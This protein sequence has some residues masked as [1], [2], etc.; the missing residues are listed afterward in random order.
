MRNHQYKQ[1][2]FLP[3][4]NSNPL[5]YELINLVMNGNED[6]GD[7]RDLEGSNEPDPKRARIDPEISTETAQ[8]S[9]NKSDIIETD[10]AVINEK[11][12]E[13][14]TDDIGQLK[15]LITLDYIIF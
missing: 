14:A 4:T 13:I 2:L 3:S 1:A 12:T 9:E 6:S 5:C 11:N 10:E 7:Q 8:T 15:T